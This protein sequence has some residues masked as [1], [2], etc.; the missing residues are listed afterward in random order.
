MIKIVGIVGSPRIRGNTERLVSEVLRVAEEEGARTELIRLADKKLEGCNH[1]LSCRKTG[2]C[3]IKDDFQP[4]FEKM[5]EA[6]GII[7]ASPV[8][9][10]SATP[11]IKALIDR[12]GYLSFSP[13]GRGRVFENKVGAPL[14]VGRR[15]G[16]NFTL[17]ELMFFFLH[18]GMIIPGSSQWNVAIGFEKGEV[19]KDEEGIETV[20]NFGIKMVWLIKIIKK[21]KKL[22]YVPKYNPR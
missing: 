4:I 7:L 6:D 20:Q 17:A 5:V 16:Q 9:F 14:V 13:K 3:I 15:A 12:A 18:Q 2:E 21:E 10:S 22:K 1:C 11:E 8:Y 19:E